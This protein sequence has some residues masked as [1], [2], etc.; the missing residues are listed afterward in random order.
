MCK[1]GYRFNLA[2]LEMMSPEGIEETHEKYAVRIL[3]RF[4]PGTSRI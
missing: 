3:T 2:I 1:E 4:E